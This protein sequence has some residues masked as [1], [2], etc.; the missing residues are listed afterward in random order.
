M[1]A[2][3]SVRL[4]IALV[5]LTLALTVGAVVFGIRPQGSLGAVALAATLGAIAFLALGYLLAALLPS[6]AAA[7]PVCNMLV[8]GMLMLSGATAP[9]AV[10]P[11][12]AQDVAQFSPMTQLVNLVGGLWSG[13]PWA[14]HWVAVAAL[15]GLTA[16]AS[17]ISAWRFRW[18]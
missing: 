11:R 18:E 17:S 5:G 3:V 6:Q 7:L 1:L 13:D 15:A 10:M 9:L 4:V 8:I 16:G 2:D 14:E 12:W